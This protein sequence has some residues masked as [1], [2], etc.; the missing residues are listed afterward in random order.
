[1]RT[2]ICLCRWLVAVVLAGVLA[3]QGC[4]IHFKATDVEL[5]T[6]ENTTYMLERIDF[7]GGETDKS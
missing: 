4:T 3:C 7:L 5:D 2:K 1:M 6:E